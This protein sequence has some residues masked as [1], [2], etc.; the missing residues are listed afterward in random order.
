[1]KNRIRHITFWMCLLVPLQLIWFGAIIWSFNRQAPT[2]EAGSE[3]LATSI[4]MVEVLLTLLG[5]GLAVMAF[6][7]YGVFKGQVEEQARTAATKVARAAT[8]D[9]L[10]ADSIKLIKSALSDDQLISALQ[11]R[12]NELGIDDE[13]DAAIVDRGD[14]DPNDW[15]KNL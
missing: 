13:D 9:Y 11:I 8:F 10:D 12:M 2:S 3:I 5:I 1:M 14:D 15:E 4:T 6:M 7:G